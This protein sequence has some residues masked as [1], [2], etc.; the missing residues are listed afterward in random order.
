M[1][2]IETIQTFTLCSLLLSTVVN[3]TMEKQEREKDLLLLL[4]GRLIFCQNI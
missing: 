1:H 3:E 4:N 2:H